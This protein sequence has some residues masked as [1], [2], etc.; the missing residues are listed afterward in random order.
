MASTMYWVVGGE[1]RSFDFDELKE[2]TGRVFGPFP[3][4]EDAETV[5]RDTSERHRCQSTMRF[6][7]VAEA[8]RA[9]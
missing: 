2:G 1:Y 6:T 9:A 8:A 5:W 7:I 4:R 3:S